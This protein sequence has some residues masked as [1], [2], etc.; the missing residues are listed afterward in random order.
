MQGSIVRK[1]ESF[2]GRDGDMVSFDA[3]YLVDS[4]GNSHRISEK[5]LV[6]P[7]GA[8]V[9]LEPVPSLS[10]SLRVVVRSVTSP[11]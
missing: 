3:C 9:D 4:D 6:L 10:G 7:Q 5:A 11:K 2:K 1:S 8:K